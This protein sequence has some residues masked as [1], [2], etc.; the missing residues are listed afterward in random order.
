MA[1]TFDF[2]RKVIAE[3]EAGECKDTNMR[4]VGP[5]DAWGNSIEYR[6]FRVSITVT[7]DGPDG[8]PNTGDYIKREQRL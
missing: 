4:G 7:S 5:D 3:Q 8:K 1:H 2:M 6:C